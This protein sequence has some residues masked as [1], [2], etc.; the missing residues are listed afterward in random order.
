ML[1]FPENF[2]EIR[3]AAGGKFFQKKDLGR[4][5]LSSRAN[6]VRPFAHG[7]TPFAHGHFSRMGSNI[8]TAAPAHGTLAERRAFA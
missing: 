1:I 7:K 6:G 2:P 5:K 8:Y 3:C 4:R